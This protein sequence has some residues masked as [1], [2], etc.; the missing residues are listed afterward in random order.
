VVRAVKRFIKLGFKVAVR[1]EWR[2]ES[3]RCVQRGVPDLPQGVAFAPLI[4]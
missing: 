1:T 3:P 4:V 2:Y